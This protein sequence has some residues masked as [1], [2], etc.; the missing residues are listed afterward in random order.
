MQTTYEGQQQLREH[1]VRERD[2]TLIRHFKEKL[3]D[4][5]CTICNF[6]FQAVYGPIGRH[7]IEA[8]HVEPIGLREGD[9]PTLLADLIAVCS[10][11]H[12]MLHRRAPPFGPNELAIAMAQSFEPK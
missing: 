8:H 11:C 9:A 5:S 10:N 1:L 7:F 2:P 12:R 4:F 3:R 6:D